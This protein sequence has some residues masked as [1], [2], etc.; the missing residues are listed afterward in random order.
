[1]TKRNFLGARG[2]SLFYNW[3][4]DTNQSRITSGAVVQ[5]P[6]DWEY[7]SSRTIPGSSAQK[8]LYSLQFHVRYAY[9]INLRLHS[10]P[11]YYPAIRKWWFLARTCAVPKP[12]NII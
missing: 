10:R 1:M 8:P 9:R 4:L 6:C 3:S 12:C 2:P 11:S 5:T 7:A